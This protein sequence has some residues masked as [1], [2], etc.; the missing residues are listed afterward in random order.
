MTG[1]DGERTGADGESWSALVPE[2]LVTDLDQSLAFYRLCGFRLRFS[3][4]EDGFA[5]LELGAAQIMLEQLSDEAWQTGTLQPPFGRGLN[6]Q[7]EIPD[8]AALAAGLQAAGQTLFRP[9]ETEWYSQD[10]AEHGQSQFLVQDP[11]GYLQRFVQ[12][13]ATR[14]VRP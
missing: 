5:Y 1:A 6:L 8:A 11:D 14:A 13:L 10:D 3:R 7:I 9:L 4:P 12:P 2:L